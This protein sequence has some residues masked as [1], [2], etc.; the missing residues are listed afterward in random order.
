MI[1]F[2]IL[3]LLLLLLSNCDFLLFVSFEL[4]LPDSTDWLSLL[5]ILSLVI[6]FVDLVSLSLAPDEDCM[7]SAG[8]VVEVFL[9]DVVRR[10]VSDAVVDSLNVHDCDWDILLFDF[11]LF[12]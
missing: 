3:L 11:F 1:C 12:F 8:F 4:E 7:L 6:E 2:L 5:F 9:D 10:D